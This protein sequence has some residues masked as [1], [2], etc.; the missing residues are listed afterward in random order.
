M[1]LPETQ[2]PRSPCGDRGSG[3]V[4]GALIQRT[5]A[6]LQRAPRQGK[7]LGRPPTSPILLHAARDLVAAGVPVAQAARQKGVARS[8]LQRFLRVSV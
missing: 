5:K 3:L 7:R 1:P 8:T 4:T 2:N 6:G